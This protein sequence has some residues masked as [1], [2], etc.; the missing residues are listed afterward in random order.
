MEECK[1][2]E[3]LINLK[4]RMHVWLPAIGTIQY[5]DFIS[6]ASCRFG[7]ITTLLIE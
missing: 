7:K 5:D 2:K 1:K 6:K 4:T 3:V